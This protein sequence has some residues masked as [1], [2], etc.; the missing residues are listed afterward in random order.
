MNGKVYTSTAAYEPQKIDFFSKKVEIEF[1]FLLKCWNNPSFVNISSTEV[2]DTSKEMFSR[3]LHHGN[4]EIGFYL[5]NAYLS[6][7]AAL[8]CQSFLTYTVLIDMSTFLCY[9]LYKHSSWYQHISMLPTCTFMFRQV[10]TIKPSFFRTTCGMHRRPFKDRHLD[11]YIFL[12]S[13]YI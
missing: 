6:V 2:I 5:K 9:P 13:P 11:I 4:P 8:F 3:V 12:Y 7:S 1:W 10:C